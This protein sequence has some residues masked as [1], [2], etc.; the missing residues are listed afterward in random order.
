MKAALASVKFI[1]K[2]LNFNLSQI[3]KYS[4]MAKE[5]GADLIV[6][7]EA[8]LQ[9]FDSLSWNHEEDLK[10]A[11]PRDGK[12]IKAIKDMSLKYGIDIMTGYIEKDG[13]NIY[14]SEILV[15]GS[16]ML[17]NY[18]RVS[19]GWREEDRTDCHYLEGNDSGPFFYKDKSYGIALCG[20]LW[21]K[22]TMQSFSFRETLIWPLYI[23]YDEKE[24][25]S[26]G[27]NEYARQAGHFAR[28]VLMVN[29][30]SSSPDEV[31]TGGAFVF[32]NGKATQ[33][34][35]TGEEGLLVVDL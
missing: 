7:G 9:G 12:E 29:S 35:Y 27:E 22:D 2:D 24:W 6:F 20:D 15:S 19:T 30:V 32:E 13:G 1:N 33:R 11:V 21:D 31:S 5:T 23:N 25:L 8:F 14:S 4:R 16:E 17:Y 18:R 28:K 34:F 26:T 10:T 3:D